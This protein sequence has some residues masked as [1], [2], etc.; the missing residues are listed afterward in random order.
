MDK[1]ASN[2]KYIQEKVS[3]NAPE[4]IMILFGFL[5]VSIPIFGITN[6]IVDFDTPIKSVF[7]LLWLLG[8]GI[9]GSWAIQNQPKDHT[10]LVDEHDSVEF[11]P[12]VAEIAEKPY[13][14]WIPQEL[15]KQWQL[16]A[17][18]K[19]TLNF[20]YTALD[21]ILQADISDIWTSNTTIQDIYEHIWAFQASIVR[22]SDAL[23]DI[24]PEDMDVAE[25]FENREV[26]YKYLDYLQYEMNSI[27]QISR[28]MTSTIQTWMVYNHIEVTQEKQKME[29]LL[30]E[31]HDKISS[32]MSTLITATEALRARWDDKQV[33]QI[34]IRQR[35]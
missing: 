24:L 17:E 31:W 6:V 34:L 35:I 26:F 30:T 29:Q 9:V 32:Y 33:E 18:R 25:D 4:W 15:Y 20:R 21:T 16:Y 7:M 2:R 22:A 14:N 3:P 10:F 27:Q 12:E 23:I 28:D 1:P 11:V 8:W 19:S 5:M 13:T